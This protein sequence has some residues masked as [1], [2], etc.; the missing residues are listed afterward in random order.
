MNLISALYPNERCDSEW[1]IVCESPIHGRGLYAAKDIPAGEYMIQYVGEKI[2]KDESDRRGWE[3]MDL[4]NETGEAAVYIFTL[5]G[6]WD[7]DIWEELEIWITAL[8]DIKKGEELFF[9]Y[10]FD[11]ENYKDHPCKCGTERC[12]GYIAGEDYWPALKKKLK[13]KENAKRRKKEA[14]R[15]RAS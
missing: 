5:D 2:D 3:Q 1:C 4:A 12:V 13:R 11:L 10:G 9:N 8:R 6:E 15:K 14:L 7:I